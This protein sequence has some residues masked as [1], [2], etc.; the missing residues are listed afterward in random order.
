MKKQIEK[1]Y[2]Q[3]DLLLERVGKLDKAIEAFQNVCEHKHEDGSDA[4][5]HTGNDS[6]HTWY[7]C[8]ICGYQ[9]H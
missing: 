7:K 1:F 6:H 4:L 9:T 3:R 5:E 8:T 2:T